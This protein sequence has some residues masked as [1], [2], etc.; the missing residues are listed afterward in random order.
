MYLLSVAQLG[1]GGEMG[2][3]FKPRP[4]HPYR[5]HKFPNDT[6]QEN[7]TAGAGLS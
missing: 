5:L 3:G 4:V 7:H 2:V 6:A 1:R